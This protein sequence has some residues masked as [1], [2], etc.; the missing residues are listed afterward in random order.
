MEINGGMY[1][2]PQAGRLENLQ[3]QKRLAV[4]GYKPTKQTEALWK[5]DTKTITFVL[6]LDDFGVK[7]INKKDVED[8]IKNVRKKLR[9]NISGLERCI[10]L[11]NHVRI[12]LPS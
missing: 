2:L 3:L 10:I 11:W 12:E 4:E 6:V 1:G 8:L 5:H 9:R 7:Y